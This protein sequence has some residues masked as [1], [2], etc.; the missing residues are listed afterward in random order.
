M[1]FYNGETSTMDI[2]L[3]LNCI[4]F[5]T[6]T[7]RTFH[8]GFLHLTSDELDSTKNPGL[9]I[10]SCTLKLKPVLTHFNGC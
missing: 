4:G 1:S 8:T 7:V 9:S 3:D 5:S 6:L 2:N 10:E